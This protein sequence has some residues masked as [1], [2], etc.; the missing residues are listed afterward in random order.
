MFGNQENSLWV[1]SFRPNT[2]D[3]YVGNEHII[4]KVKVYIENGDVPQL[5]FYGGAGTGKTTLA[6]IIANNVDA[7]VMYINA[8]D[9]NNIENMISGF[10]TVFCIS[11]QHQLPRYKNVIP[12]QDHNFINELQNIDIVFLN[13]NYDN[14][15]FQFIPQLTRKC[16]PVI[17]LN[18]SLVLST[19]YIDL[20]RRI[21]Y[22]QITILDD[23]QIWK[24]IRK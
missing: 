14:S 3:G 16:A 13:I 8:S 24:I 5:L 4:E 12:I 23:Y 10:N 22:E 6:K 19:E 21:R 20:F 2:L 18:N 9:E 15:I 11:Y 17:F 7:D 1:E